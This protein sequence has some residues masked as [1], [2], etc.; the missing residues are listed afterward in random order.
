M[1]L[2]ER[3]NSFINAVA[4]DIKSLY[5]NKVNK[6][7]VI[8]VA[9]GGTGATDAETARGNLGLGTAAS[10]QV[11]LAAGNVMEVG[12]F[13]LGT[14]ALTQIKNSDLNTLQ[15]SGYCTAENTNANY[16]PETNATFCNIMVIPHRAGYV[17]QLA[18]MIGGGTSNLIWVRSCLHNTWGSWYKIYTAQNTFVDDNG[19]IKAASPIVSL[20]ADK[21]ELNDEAKLQQ[22]SF[23]KNGVGDYL[24]K[25]S[26]GFAQEGWYIEMPKDANGNVLV[27]VVY[28]QLA[29]NDI[30][31]KTYDYMLN[32]KGRIIADLETPLDIPATR[33]V[34]L[35]LQALPQ[36]EIKP[37]STD[38]TVN[39]TD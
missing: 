7:D 34:D 37:F 21:I 6:T 9:Q 22:I 23:V 12:A 2:I 39:T 11:G 10:R 28:E 35:R 3:I 29:N 19:F 25:G 8:A 1:T 26:T 27:A 38:E 31:V 4:S 13:G 33:R 30:S 20:Y 16:P 24:I 15:T 18:F 14:D 32:K 5:T 36:P 17:T